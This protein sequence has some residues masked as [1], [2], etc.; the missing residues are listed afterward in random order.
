MS[1]HYSCQPIRFSFLPTV[2]KP[3]GQTHHQCAGSDLPEVVKLAIHLFIFDVTAHVSPQRGFTHTTKEAAHMPTQ[4]VHLQ[5]RQR[6]QNRDQYMSKMSHHR[7]VYI[8]KD[9]GQ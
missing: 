7:W 8:E 5:E 4:V 1:I 3:K 6:Q 2:F 9:R